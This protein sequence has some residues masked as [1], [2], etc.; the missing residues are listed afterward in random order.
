MS[1]L[2]SGLG[3]W[4]TMVLSAR[5]MLSES[6]L[7]FPL[8]V[9]M[10]VSLISIFIIICAHFKSLLIEFEN[11][12]YFG[13]VVL[14]ATT[15]LLSSVIISWFLCVEI[16]TLD[17]S[18][19]FSTCYLLN[20]LWLIAPRANCLKLGKFWMKRMR[21]LMRASDRYMSCTSYLRLSVLWSCWSCCSCMRDSESSLPEPLP[22]R[23]R[24]EYNEDA[25]VRD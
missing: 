23:R 4:A 2:V 14:F 6:I 17:L 22:R 3:L 1:V 20:T 24:V 18:F 12:F 5:M 21:M 16:P 25:R 7:N 15:P 11:S 10:G 19:C 9:V 13:E 8:V